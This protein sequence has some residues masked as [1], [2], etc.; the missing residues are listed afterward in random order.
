LLKLKIEGDTLKL[1]NIKIRDIIF[2]IISIF[3]LT[4]SI[5]K[6]MEQ[7]GKIIFKSSKT[8]DLRK[9]NDY[10]L[11]KSFDI[12]DDQSNKINKSNE[13]TTVDEKIKKINR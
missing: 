9:I 6:Y 3:F 2:I 5:V 8:L 4:L 12:L 11:Q 7:S 1:K 10:K 13:T